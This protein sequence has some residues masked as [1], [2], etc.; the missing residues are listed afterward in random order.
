MMKASEDF[1]CDL[2]SEAKRHLLFLKMVHALG[3]SLQRPS[4]ESLRRYS[5]LWLPLVGLES[6]DIL[7]KGFREGLSLIPPPDIAWLWHCHRLAPFLYTEYVNQE[8]DMSDKMKLLNPS[9]PFALQMDPD[10]VYQLLPSYQSDSKGKFLWINHSSAEDV[11]ETRRL[12]NT[13]Y[14]KEAFFTLPFP[15][16]QSAQADKDVTEENDGILGLLHSYN[17]RDAAI[18]QS[19]FLWQVQ[20]QQYNDDNFLKQGVINYHKFIQLKST[21][22]GKNQL[23]VPTYQIDLIW[24]THILFSIEKYYDDCIKVAGSKMNHDDSINDRHEGG[25]L[26]LSFKATKKL[27]EQ[28]YGE[29]Y[30]VEGGMFLGDPPEAF[31]S[32]RRQ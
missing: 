19:T 15:Q 8:L 28:T 9:A 14:P 23:I 3:V 32:P 1:S 22:T 27:W 11:K 10:R 25:L 2:V 5:K 17:L 7:D 21:E 30:S 13:V 4:D 24:H 16:D 31:F 20:G 26:D 18:R 6:K 29:S 12:W